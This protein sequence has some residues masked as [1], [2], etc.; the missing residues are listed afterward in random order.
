MRDRAPRAL[1]RVDKLDP[2]LVVQP[3]VFGAP[4]VKTRIVRVDNGGV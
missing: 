4:H 2:D 3:G 1:G